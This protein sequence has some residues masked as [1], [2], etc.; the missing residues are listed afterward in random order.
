MAAALFLL[1]FA[2]Q[3]IGPGPGSPDRSR[4]L[5]LTVLAFP[6]LTLTGA[7]IALLI[8]SSHDRA[9]TLLRALSG[10]LAGLLLTAGLGAILMSN[11]LQDAWYF[12]TA[13]L[14]FGIIPAGLIGLITGGL[15]SLLERKNP[16]NP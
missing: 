14:T 15:V 9:R 2:A 16:P 8:G 13:V 11:S 5:V 7:A 12:A 6:V 1:P 4:G 10:A 3:A